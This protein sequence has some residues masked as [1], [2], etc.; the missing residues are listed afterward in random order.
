VELIPVDASTGRIAPIVAGA[1]R[2]TLPILRAMARRLGW[3]EGRAAK[4][5][6]P[7]FRSPNGGRLCFEPGG[8]IEYAAPP[9]ESV[10]DWRR[11]S[12]AWPLRSAR[13]SRRP[14]SRS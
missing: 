3:R 5:G 2:S 11:S 13:G 10:R 14:A 6:A 9:N 8:Q 12:G 4:S 7:E 1:G